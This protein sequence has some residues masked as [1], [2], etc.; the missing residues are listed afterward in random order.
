MENE[1][2]IAPIDGY[3][4]YFVTSDGHILGKRKKS[5][6]IPIKNSLGYQRVSLVKNGKVK[7][8]LIHRLVAAAFLPNPN[9][10]PCVN[11]KDENPS[12]N[13]VENLEWCTTAYNNAYG[14]KGMRTSLAQMNR[15][16]CSKAVVQFSLQ[17]EYI[18]TFPSTKEAWRE[19]GIDRGH[20][21][22]C[23]NHYKNQYTASGYRW[24]WESEVL[25]N[26]SFD[27]SCIFKRERNS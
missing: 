13:R 19:T 25:K 1:I 7:N 3:E 26:G 5:Y 12:N 21:G 22:Q 27:L 15:K 8:F 23:C 10:F 20:I 18:T 24:A 2:Q 4:G 17:G 6:L 16:D 14:T 11:H 9:D